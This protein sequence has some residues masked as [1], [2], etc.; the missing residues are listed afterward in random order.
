MRRL[1]RLICAATLA[2]AVLAA[3]ASAAFARTFYVNGTSGNN[4]NSCE[5]SSAA[6]KTIPAAVTKSEAD[7]ETSRI[8]VAAGAYEETV[9]IHKAEDSGLTIN[10]AGGGPGG[11]QIVGPAK[12]SEATIKTVFPAT[13]ITVSNL[14]VL[15]PSGDTQS[16]VACG[17]EVSLRNVLVTMMNAGGASGIE[18]AM[19]GSLEVNGGGV[20][21]AAGTEGDAIMAR[22][23][24]LTVAN[25]TVTAAPGSKDVGIG[26][27]SGPLTV[28]NTTVDMEGATSTK[29]AVGGGLAPVSLNHVSI[30]QA[31]EASNA[32]GLELFLATPGSIS[33][34]SVSMTNPKGKAA[35]V[36]QLVGNANFSHLEVGGAWQGAAL[37]A[38]GGNVD[39]ADSHLATG[40]GSTTSALL[41]GGLGEHPGLVLQRTVLQANPGAGPGALAV[42]GGDV[43]LDSS[44]VLGGVSGVFFEQIGKKHQL[45]VSASTIDAGKPGVADGAGVFGVSAVAGG[46]SVAEAAITGS[47]VL[48]R[49]LVEAVPPAKSTVTCQY[50]DIPNQLEGGVACGAGSAGNASSA[51]SSLFSEPVTGYQLNPS[52]S[53]VGGVPAGAISL[54]FGITP[55]A[56]DLA[57]NPRTGDG[58]DPCFS[59]QDK[60]A[61][62]L[63]GHLVNCPS[64]PPPVVQ[65]LAKPVA[66]VISALTISPSAFL[67]A[68]KG[69]TISSA[70]SA[71]KK[72]YGAKITYR[73]SQAATTTFTVL[74]PLAGRMQGKSCKKPGRSNKHG[75]DCTLYKP[76]G[77]FTHTDVAGANSLHFSG[78]LHAKKLA[79]GSYRLQA[80]AHDAAGN[81]A[82]VNKGFTIK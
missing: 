29:F 34:V 49:Q 36:E 26:D 79:K 17:G 58:V 81:G 22:A 80:V 67:A 5:A 12:A 8:E 56:S 39:L 15:N 30:T 31:G 59:A 18:S 35:A 4:A 6:C 32:P 38:E 46:A 57:G 61:L 10:G 16:G 9:L 55:S 48:E 19:F 66:G 3:G 33:N 78:R 72:K 27:E 60:G 20:V 40:A 21:M 47:V 53:A 63:Q 23:T 11:T 45:T 13:G 2:A 71:T 14:S 51:V 74:L 70:S 52:S 76:L 24:A 82:A 77:S 62:E 43:T 25:A 44:E 65:P 28:S 64:S 68:P 41:Y 37:A 7:P 1:W 42:F 75:R 69:A 73:D 54:P 50:S